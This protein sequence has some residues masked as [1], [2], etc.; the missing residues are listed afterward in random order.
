M[1]TT[2][3]QSWWGREGKVPINHNSYW[4]DVIMLNK[5]SGGEGGGKEKTGHCSSEIKSLVW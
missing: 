4:V 5:S 1:M 2:D 3:D